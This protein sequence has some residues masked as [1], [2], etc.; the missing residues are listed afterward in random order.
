MKGSAPGRK[1]EH[2]YHVESV[3]WDGVNQLYGERIEL[4]YVGGVPHTYTH[5]PPSPPPPW[6]M[7]NSFQLYLVSYINCVVT[8]VS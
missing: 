7:G 1:G 4:Q 6:D 2:T 5:T 3:Q 8:I